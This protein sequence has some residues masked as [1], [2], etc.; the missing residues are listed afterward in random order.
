MEDKLDLDVQLLWCSLIV[1]DLIEDGGKQSPSW[2]N[3]EVKNPV[4][5]SVE[6]NPKSFLKL[7]SLLDFENDS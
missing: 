4:P 1:N 3:F 2:A 7:D 5:Q 6:Y